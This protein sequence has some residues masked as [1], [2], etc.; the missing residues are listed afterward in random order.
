[1]DLQIATTSVEREPQMALTPHIIIWENEKFRGNHRHIFTEEP[2]LNDPEDRTLENKV[3]S[4]VV[5]E[6]E[7]EFFRN[8]NF[9][10]AY[11]GSPSFTQGE[12]PSISAVGITNDTVTSVRSK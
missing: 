6:G 7:W 3:S 4:F 10:G 5:L 8:P 11:L 2:D 1:M 12:Y 9:S